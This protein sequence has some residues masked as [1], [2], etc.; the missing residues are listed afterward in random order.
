[1]ADPY[2]PF[3]GKKGRSWGELDIPSIAGRVAAGAVPAEV[4]DAV[5]KLAAACKASGI[6]LE[7][8]KELL[9]EA[10][11][12]EVSATSSGRNRR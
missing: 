1:M 4:E 8:A 9:K 2:C 12:P 3:V 6:G 5:R 7:R 11:G 10:F